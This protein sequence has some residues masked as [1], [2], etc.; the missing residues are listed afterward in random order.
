MG[1]LTI[2]PIENY[3]QPFIGHKISYLSSLLVTCHLSSRLY[4]VDIVAFSSFNKESDKV[5]KHFLATFEDS[6]A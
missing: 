1:S 2:L 5:L 4:G 6:L 3:N